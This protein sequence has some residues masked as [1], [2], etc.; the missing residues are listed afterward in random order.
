MC[1]FFFPFFG[2]SPTEIPEIRL[3]G[4][5]IKKKKKKVLEGSNKP[6]RKKK[7]KRR[8]RF[9]KKI[10]KKYFPDIPYSFNHHRG[11]GYWAPSQFENNPDNNMEIRTH[12]SD[13]IKLYGLY[14]P[15]AA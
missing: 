15:R 14:T 13:M 4:V 2:S 6:K 3:K 1:C 5:N 7:A 9:K 10:L 12:D 8:N 11:R